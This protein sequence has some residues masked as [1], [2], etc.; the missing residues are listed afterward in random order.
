MVTR[1][2]GIPVLKDNYCWLFIFGEHC[3][4]IDPGHDTPIL[5]ALE[6]H[7]LKPVAICATHHHYDHTDGIGGIL[8]KYPDCEVIYGSGEPVSQGTIAL[9]H[10][11]ILQ[12]PSCPAIQAFST[13]GHTKH[14]T[15]FLIDHHLFTGD[16]LFTAG[17]GRAFECP[18]ATLYESMSLYHNLAEDLI[19]HSGHEYTEQ[20]LTFAAHVWPT[21]QYVQQALTDTIRMRKLGIPTASCDLGQIKKQNIF[22]RT[23]DKNLWQSMPQNKTPRSSLECFEILRDWKNNFFSGNIQ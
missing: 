12:L 6:R 7:Q 3:F 21:D 5:H 1:T 8:S 10:E 18:C 11:Q 16:T 22:L 13:P 15:T 20:D 9:E 19:V 23:H 4:I 17:C 2:L 14:S